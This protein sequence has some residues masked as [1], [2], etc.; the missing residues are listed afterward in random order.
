MSDVSPT[1]A[2]NYRVSIGGKVDK[3]NVGLKMPT[4]NQM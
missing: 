2:D 4:Q 3:I 1:A